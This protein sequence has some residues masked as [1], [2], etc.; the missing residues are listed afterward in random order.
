MLTHVSRSESKQAC[1][2]EITQGEVLD[3][4]GRRG[5]EGTASS[6]AGPWVVFPLSLCGMHTTDRILTVLSVSLISA[7]LMGALKINASQMTLSDQFCLFVFIMS[8]C[9][10]KSQCVGLGKKIRLVFWG[11]NTMV[12]YKHMPDNTFS[13]QCWY[14]RFPII[15]II[16]LV[17]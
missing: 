15:Q 16:Y 14:R 8:L 2:F 7:I 1:A 3:E 10:G 12:I 5:E 4:P 17:L 11:W 9:S 6:C 13:L